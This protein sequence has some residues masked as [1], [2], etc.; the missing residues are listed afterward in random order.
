VVHRGQIV[1]LI[2]LAG[3]A[4][5]AGCNN[6]LGERDSD[7]GERVSLTKLRDVQKLSL[8][9]F[10]R[11]A[12]EPAPVQPP[13]AEGV[14]DQLRRPPSRFAGKSEVQLTLDQVRA[15][16]LRNN[17]DL[18]VA[19]VDPSI[20]NESLNAERAKF[21]AVFRPFVRFNHTEPA[22][23]NTTVSNESESWNYGGTVDIPLRSG[24]RASVGLT[25]GRVSTVPNPFNP[26]PVF[27]TQGL[28]F[29]VSQPL[30]RN[31]GRTVNTTSIQIAGY[32]EQIAQSRTKLTLIAQLAV[33]E[34]AYWRL[35]A[36]RKA[37]DVTQQQYEL[38]A[39]QLQQAQ[40]RVRAGQSAEL[41]VTRAQ[42][43]LASRLES[44]VVAENEVLIQQRE[45]KRRM[46]AA[47][48]DIA[49]TELIIPATLPE[50]IGFDLDPQS[51][52]VMALGE[53]MEL[54]E[55]ELQILADSANE[56]LARNQVLPLLD[57]SGTYGIDGIGDSFNRAQS[58]GIGQRDFQ[59]WSFGAQ[60]EIP[61]GNEA[62]EARLRRAVLVRAQRLATKQVREQTVRQ[63]VLDAVDQIRATW[64]RILAAREATIL[65][66]RVLQGEQRQFDVGQR[67]STDVLNAATSLQD[68]QVAEIR[69]VTAYQIAQVDLAVA[70]GTILGAAGVSWAPDTD[71]SNLPT[72]NNS[73]SPLAPSF[74]DDRK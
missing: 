45:L 11:A 16:A 39:T 58:T 27:Y 69:A 68:A 42:S 37:L 19:L 51:L 14:P 48:L 73:G 36:A 46:N 35:F 4:S 43:G 25:Q 6:P 3:T 64:Q 26:V 30:L 5:I 70:T 21:N 17:L 7:L 74:I 59:S 9:Q 62:A 60:A 50:P 8:D 61:L 24:G 55:T 63:D 18:K 33:V 56:R 67:T 41:E 12:S 53:R 65:A 2:L 40:R 54:L 66:G 57:L 32:N 31:G 23:T 28:D 29:S 38:A 1:G 71:V 72:T 22:T 20:A 49:G 13:A 44:I 52:Q 47:D 10:K 15:E 34:R